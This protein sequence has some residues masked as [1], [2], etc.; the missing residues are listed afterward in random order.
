MLATTKQNSRSVHDHN[1]RLSF[2]RYISGTV[3]GTVSDP[4]FSR[5]QQYPILFS[6]PA[7]YPVV[8]SVTHISLSQRVSTEK[9]ETTG[10]GSGL[11]YE[12]NTH[13]EWP[14]FPYME[15][16][17]SRSPFGT[18]FNAPSYRIKRLKDVHLASWHFAQ[19]R[20]A[21]RL[22]MRLH[23][24]SRSRTASEFR[25]DG[26]LPF[27]HISESSELLK[28]RGRA[29]SREKKYRSRDVESFHGGGIHLALH[30]LS[31]SILSLFRL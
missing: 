12:T 25:K 22:D 3:S 29:L 13:A 7:T 14:R 26:I 23:S 19:H 30:S 5:A 24:G 6:E 20:L 18:A 17:C 15:K 21:F 9:R 4:F 28:N 16:F 27:S 10:G 31:V 11:P 2:T 8:I 1:A